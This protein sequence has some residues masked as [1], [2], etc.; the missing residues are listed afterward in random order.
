LENILEEYLKIIELLHLSPHPE[1]GYYNEIYRSEEVLSNEAIP[2]RYISDRNISTSIYF[3]LCKNQV[4]HFHRIQSDEIWH[5]Y[6]G[7]SIIVHCLSKDGYSK[8]TVGNGILAGQTPQLIISKGTW[9]AAELEDKTSF[10]LIGCTVAPGFNFED[11]ELGN[12][13]DLLKLYPNQKEV[14]NRLSLK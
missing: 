9:F 8:H 10:S 11:F 3:M 2:P 4:S 12:A 1:G 13:D 14:I 5:Y 7:S 6:K